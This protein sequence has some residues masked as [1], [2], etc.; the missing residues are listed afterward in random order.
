VRIAVTGIAGHVGGFVARELD[1]AG[2][3][4]VGVDLR[5]PAGLP[6][7]RF[8]R[9]DVASQAELGDAFAGCDAVVHLAAIRDLGLAPDAEL[10]Q[11]NVVGT[12]NA[13]EAAVAAGVPRFVFASSEAAVGMAAD[14]ATPDYL[15]IDEEH[16][17]RPCDAYALSKVLGEELCRS[18]AARGALSAICLR[19]AYVFS[20]EESRIESA[21]L[22][23]AL[24]SPETEEA[25]RRGIW[26]Y[27]DARD[28]ARAYRLACEAE[29]VR[30]AAVFVVANDLIVAAPTAELVAR[31]LAGVAVRAPLGEFGPLISWARA[32]TV[33]G[34]EPRHRWRDLVGAGVGATADSA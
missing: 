3:E 14:D 29:G 10:F 4:V 33:L 32:K 34:Y 9:A 7:T 13:L 21:A 15:P 28:A 11:V 25:A 6:L 30:Y 8:A 2:H 26:S 24:S 19:T 20:L 31:R 18:Y 1:G 17:L 23:Q 16:P 22:E 12:F 5:E 27:V